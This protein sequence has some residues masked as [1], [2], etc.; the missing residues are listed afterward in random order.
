VNTPSGTA[1][2]DGTP[3]RSAARSSQEGPIGRRARRSVA[4]IGRRGYD[5]AEELAWGTPPVVE[6]AGRSR[7]WMLDLQKLGVSIV[8]LGGAARP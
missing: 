4:G 6:A 3:A 7:G 1:E 2:R 5:G 8:L